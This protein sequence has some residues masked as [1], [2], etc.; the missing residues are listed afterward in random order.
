MVC[1][2]FNIFSFVQ[3]F[4]NVDII[5]H[6]NFNTCCFSQLIKNKIKN[7]IQVCFTYFASRYHKVTF[8]FFEE[9]LL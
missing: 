5:S 9:T 6:Q 4:S 1:P 3:T 8:C 2:V 7:V